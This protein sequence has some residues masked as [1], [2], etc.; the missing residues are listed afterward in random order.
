M[1][2]SWALPPR[3][4]FL[5][6]PVALFPRF[7]FFWGGV[8]FLGPFSAWL[9]VLRACL[10]FPRFLLLVFLTPPWPPPSL[11]GARGGCLS[12]T[13]LSVVCVVAARV[14]LP[15]RLGVYGVWPGSSPFFARVCV[16]LPLLPLLSVLCATLSPVAPSKSPRVQ[17]SHDPFQGLKNEDAPRNVNVQPTYLQEARHT[18]L[19]ETFGE[20]CNVPRRRTRQDF[21]RRQFLAMR[22]TLRC[23][24]PKGNFF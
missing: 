18:D 2:F 12:F 22:W 10:L 17:A 21:F 24:P 13:P 6:A 19:L 15:F 5:C 11:A 16:G 7:P 14:P 4:L 20:R 9:W 1:I 23:V 8:R 3:F